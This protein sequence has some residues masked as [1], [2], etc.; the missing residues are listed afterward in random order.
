MQ[1]RI[2]ALIITDGI[3]VVPICIMAFLSY[4]GVEMPNT[5]Y[6][7]TTCFL[8]PINSALNPLIYSKVGKN[9]LVTVLKWIKSLLFRRSVTAEPSQAV[10]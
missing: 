10:N 2:A 1:K 6:I 3:C 9:A 5:A 7:A 8:L 4:A